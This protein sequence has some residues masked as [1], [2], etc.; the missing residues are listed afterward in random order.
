MNKDNNGY[1]YDP[2]SP[3]Y[4]WRHV[5]ILI[6]EQ[7]RTSDMTFEIDGEY[8]AAGGNFA[9]DNFTVSG[10]STERVSNG[11][12]QKG[13]SLG[14]NY[15]NPLSTRTSFDFTLPERANVHITL[16]DVSGKLVKEIANDAFEGGTHTMTFQA[17]G[18]A[19][20][21]Y[22]YL[23]ESAGI[24]LARQMVVSK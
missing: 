15:P 20:G 11:A 7:F 22:I 10:T 17:D 6:P 21:T 19:A 3:E 16:L 5:K 4:F 1:R 24:R 14:E 12:S 9:F 8:A 23:L 18:I 13:Y 2:Y